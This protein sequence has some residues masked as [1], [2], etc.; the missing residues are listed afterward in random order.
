MVLFGGALGGYVTGG[1]AR[2]RVL[3][4]AHFVWARKGPA[5]EVLAEPGDM[6]FMEFWSLQRLLLPL[7][8]QDQKVRIP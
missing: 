8:Q 3:A 5:D 6:L 2:G 1:C 4:E 7:N